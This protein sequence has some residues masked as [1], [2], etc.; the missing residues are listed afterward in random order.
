MMIQMSKA[1][2]PE[3]ALL[4]YNAVLRNLHG[5]N[6]AISDAVK[7]SITS[8]RAWERK[9]YIAELMILKRPK[10]DYLLVGGS[11]NQQKLSD[12]CKAVLGRSDY[13]KKRRDG[14]LSGSLV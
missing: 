2:I 3:D 14:R 11:V 7:K 5:D 10:F 12:E 1:S 13:V 4:C 6:K 9:R 8:W